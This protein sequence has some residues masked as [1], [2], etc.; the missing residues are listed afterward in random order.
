L[1]VIL[2]NVSVNLDLKET[3]IVDAAHHLRVL[4]IQAH[5]DL[6]QSAQLLRKVCP[7]VVA[8]TVTK[9]IQWDPKVVVQI[10]E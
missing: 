8:L 2:S 9:V 7:C 10:A 3:H 4:A 1:L 6:M 5:A